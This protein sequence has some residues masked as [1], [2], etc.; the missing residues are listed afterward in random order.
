VYYTSS[1]R[2]ITD[3][4]VSLCSARWRRQKAGSRPLR[5]GSGGGDSDAASVAIGTGRRASELSVV[6]AALGVFVHPVRQTGGD[7]SDSV[8]ARVH[9][10][11]LPVLHSTEHLIE[12]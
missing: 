2:G 9:R 6:A 8:H 12:I 5:S 11:A 1:S 10:C 7:A 3:G 4:K